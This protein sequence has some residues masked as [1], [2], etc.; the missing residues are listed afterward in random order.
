MIQRGWDVCPRARPPLVDFL[1]SVSADVARR[2]CGLAEDDGADIA[3]EVY[4]R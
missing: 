3:R 2:A 1:D 4:R